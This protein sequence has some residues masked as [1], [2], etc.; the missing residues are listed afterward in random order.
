MIITPEHLSRPSFNQIKTFEK[1]RPTPQVPSWEASATNFLKKRQLLEALILTDD[2]VAHYGR[3]VGRRMA[4]RIFGLPISARGRGITREC[5]L[6][7]HPSRYA[8][9]Q[10]CYPIQIGPFTCI[11]N[12]NNCLF[13]KEFFGEHYTMNILSETP[14]AEPLLNGP[15]Q[16]ASIHWLAL[17]PYIVFSHGTNTLTVVDLSKMDYPSGNQ[18][19]ELPYA[20]VSFGSRVKRLC[21]PLADGTFFVTLAPELPVLSDVC[22]LFQFNMPALA[23]TIAAKSDFDAR[24]AGCVQKDIELP[25]VEQTLLDDCCAEGNVFVTCGGGMQNHEVRFIETDG[26]WT[27]RFVHEAPVVRILRTECGVM[28][29]DESGTA[30]LWRDQ[31][32]IADTK[33]NVESLPEVFSL[34]DPNTK[35]TAEWNRRRLYLTTTTPQ[36]NLK[37]ALNAAHS[38]FISPQGHRA[39]H[40]V[41]AIYHL[42]W[43]TLAM[44]ADGTLH[45]WNIQLDC[46]S[47]LWQLPHASADSDD[48]R[49]LLNINCPAIEEDPRIRLIQLF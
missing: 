6:N 17:G 39:D 37:A 42:G 47:P 28:S 46:V 1:L 41:K 31:K 8:L 32:P 5:S 45:F 40:F 27:T 9:C 49:A 13:F 7:D 43:H 24:E 44:L 26:S 33:F 2:V 34:S 10:E 15:Y 12:G 25:N 16:N 22:R 23:A 30:L 4:E 20:T 11:R 36:P 19:H 38:L 3:D 48:W 14:T 29:L 35:I 18:K 21:G